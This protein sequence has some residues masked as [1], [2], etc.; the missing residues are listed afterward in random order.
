[1]PTAPIMSTDRMDITAIGRVTVA[2][3]NG[4]VTYTGIIASDLINVGLSDQAVTLEQRSGLGYVHGVAFLDQ[5]D[6]LTI[7]FYPLPT[8]SSPT[9]DDYRALDLPALGAT[10]TVTGG[11][12]ATGSNAG[13]MMDRIGPVGGKKYTYVGGGSIT[14][15]PDGLAVMSLPCRRYYGIVPT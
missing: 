1:M 13:V 7:S 4:E 14:Q 11:T 8:A 9:A 3:A 12:A 15:T 10:V 6:A 5:Q 2:G